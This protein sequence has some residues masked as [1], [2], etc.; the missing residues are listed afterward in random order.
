L[1]LDAKAQVVFTRKCFIGLAPSL[2][3]CFGW[4]GRLLSEVIGE[5]LK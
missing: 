1:F 2:N 4:G 3:E 5:G